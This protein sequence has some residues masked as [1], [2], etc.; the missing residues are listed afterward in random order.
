MNNLRILTAV[1]LLTAACGGG[2]TGEDRVA[3]G[4]DQIDITGEQTLT[5]SEPGGCGPSDSEPGAWNGMFSTD[6]DEPWLLDVTIVSFEAPKVYET[7][8]DDESGMA[9]IFLTNGAGTTYESTDGMGGFTVEEGGL[10][11]SLD[12]V[13]TNP[14]DN[15]TVGVRGG[16]I[17]EDMTRG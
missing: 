10:S 13:L 15:S 8:A 9:S 3:L 6:G 14:E 7:S 1:L 5:I 2:E 11:G 16:F 17:C 4:G 12:V